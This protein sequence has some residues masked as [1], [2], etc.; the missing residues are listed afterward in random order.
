MNCL[1]TIGLGS[2]SAL[3]CWSR[4]ADVVEE[5]WANGSYVQV[6][7]YF[8]KQMD[9]HSKGEQISGVSRQRL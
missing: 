7:R 8:P 6:T 1:V 5:L 2:N 4:L 3:F 9:A